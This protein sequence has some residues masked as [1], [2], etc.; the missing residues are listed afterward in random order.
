MGGAAL[1]KMSLGI[2]KLFDPLGSRFNIDPT[3]RSFPMQSNLN[4]M[5]NMQVSLRIFG[6]AISLVTLT[7]CAQ[8][9]PGMVGSGAARLSVRNVGALVSIISNDANCGFAADTLAEPVA[10]G[11]SLTWRVDDCEIDFEDETVL[12]ESCDGATT[13]VSGKVIISASK[14]IAGT[15]T[16]NTDTPVIPSSPDAVTIKL[17]RVSFDNFQVKS[18]A[19][20]ATLTH[21][22][23][24]LTATAK[25]RLA[26]SSSSGVCAIVTPNV[27][28]TDIVYQS[29][30]NVVI[31]T[32]SSEIE[33]EIGGS[34]IHAQNGQDAFG[35]ENT[36]TGTI[37][38]E[39]TE[40]P[41]PGDGQG[42]DP[43]YER[44]KFYSSYGCTEDLRAPTDFECVEMDALLATGS[45]RLTAKAFGVIAS[46]ADADTT[47]GFSSPTTAASATL[48]GD[49]GSA[50]SATLSIESCEINIPS[51][52]ITDTDC[53]DVSTL[54]QGRV[55]ISGTKTIEGLVTGGAETPVIPVTDSPATIALDIELDGFK[56]WSSADANSLLLKEGALSGH[57]SPRVAVSTETGVCSASTPAV[58]FE[59]LS[60]TNAQVE[61][62]SD[63]GTFN[64]AIDGSSIHAVNGERGG[65][66]NTLEGTVRIGGTSYSVPMDGLGLNPEYDAAAFAEAWQCN[67]KYVQ[68]ISYD[69]GLENTLEP[70]LADGATRLSIKYFATVAS[71]LDADTTCGFSSA[72]ALDSAV[73]NGALGENGTAVITASQCTLTIPEGTELSPD[74]QGISTIA[75]GTVTVSGTKTLTGRISG[76]TETPVVPDSKTPAE[77]SLTITGGT[78][79][80]GSTADVNAF[81]LQ[82]GTMSGTLIPQT[83]MASANG[84]CSISTP[85]AKFENMVFANAA[86]SLISSAGQFALSLTSGSFSAV[87]GLFDGIENHLEG[88]VTLDGRI[89]DIPMDQAG[90]NP[91]YVAE[92]FANAW[93]CNPELMQP[94]NQSCDLDATMGQATARLS[95]KLFG[96]VAALVEQ[97]T[98]CGFSSHD[99]AVYPT[100]TGSLGAD[101]ST[102]TFAITEP[103][104]ITLSEPLV[105]SEDCTGAQTYLE[106]Q[107]TVTGTKVLSGYHTGNPLTPIVPSSSTPATIELEI[108]FDDAVMTT[109]QIEDPIFTVASGA[110]SGQLTPKTVIDSSTGACSISTPVATFDG[111]AWNNAEVEIESAGNRFPITIATSNLDA[112]NGKNGDRENMLDGTITV[113]GQALT[114][115]VYE[116]DAGLNPAY[117]AADF[118]AS[119]SCAENLVIPEDE[120]ACSFREVLGYA[121]GRLLSKTVGTASKL[122]N[123]NDSCGYYNLELID[124][125]TQLAGDVG[126]TGYVEWTTDA[127]EVTLP[128]D[129]Y[130][131]DCLDIQVTGSGSVTADIRKLVHGIRNDDPLIF[132]DTRDAATLTFDALEF[133]NFEV[134][135]LALG[136]TTSATA[137]SLT[138]IVTGTLNPI[139]GESGLMSTLAGMPIYAVST[140]VTGMNYQMETGSLRIFSDGNTFVVQLTDVAL[141]AFAG[142]YGERTNELSGTLTVNGQVVT[143]PVG[144]V[145]NPDYDQ[146]LL[147][148]SYACSFGL[149]GTVPPASN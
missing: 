74:C 107:V 100:M 64:V 63:S 47:C 51:E 83:S 62:A 131:A 41:V 90:L 105:V 76:S 95:T 79:S 18:S 148:E 49:I 20:E 128:E 6:L 53:N 50:G 66:E 114:I 87:N 39:G 88:Q 23:G 149:E 21:I 45:A 8:C 3:F 125:P 142:S 77:I 129:Q 135:D 55:V 133:D 103:C 80:I 2:A 7:S 115:P 141:D 46:L 1:A 34:L 72:S 57:L 5:K 29:A 38:V 37:I 146:E 54:V 109:N 104:I 126:E 108:Q 10:D 82:S 93:Q 19:S 86:V 84:I 97:D 89:F 138:G 31:D 59:G 68:P 132:P 44:T 30:S 32:G 4:E 139:A 78:L 71:L 99:V 33:A 116:G 69:C 17:T 27:A 130:P 144:T 56:V 9:A 15:I 70:V 52:T 113:G 43:E 26:A 124:N 119:Y 110:L 16:G 61:L 112:Q 98:D 137:S 96:S 48:N 35:K 102:A 75:G 13:T 92:D 36:I 134:Y 42:L 147:D 85:N 127:C 91:D 24:G 14:T 145:L 25:P 143:I 111:M 117:N 40:V 101:A 73:V 11:N 122:V 81:E 118:T 94:I 22:D 60:Y 67:E 140:P 65:S 28:F 12:S 58:I 121:A 120:Q 106:G 136:E 123:E